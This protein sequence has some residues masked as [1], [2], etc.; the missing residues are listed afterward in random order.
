[1]VFAKG[2]GKMNLLNIGASATKVSCGQF[3]RKRLVKT[4][5]IALKDGLYPQQSR[6]RGPLRR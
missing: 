1:M 4:N 5:A 3:R 6:G 2:C